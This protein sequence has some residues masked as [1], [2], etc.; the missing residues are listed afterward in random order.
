MRL[1]PLRF[2]RWIIYSSPLPRPACW[3]L[4]SGLTITSIGSQTLVSNTIV[5]N[6]NTTNLNSN[7]SSQNS[8]AVSNQGTISATLVH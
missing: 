6:G 4:F 2:A 7:Q 5:G 3:L 8:G 1:R